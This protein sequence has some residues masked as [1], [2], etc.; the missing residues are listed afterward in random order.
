MATGVLHFADLAPRD[1]DDDRVDFTR[2]HPRR[3][4]ARVRAARSRRR[5]RPLAGG[6][7]S[8]CNAVGHFS[9]MHITRSNPGSGGPVIL[10]ESGARLTES[11][12]D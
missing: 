7:E 5:G 3:L 4:D 12:V 9:D 1:V 2:K 6:G 11:R 10:D 8:L